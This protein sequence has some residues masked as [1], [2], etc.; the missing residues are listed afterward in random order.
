MYLLPLLTTYIR[1]LLTNA[2]QNYNAYSDY[3]GV[4]RFISAS[5]QT[6][7][8]NDLNLGSSLKIYKQVYF[9]WS[10]YDMI[11]WG[12]Y[13]LRITIRNKRTIWLK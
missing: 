13:I 5:V 11:H 9:A 6:N 3:H 10:L 8:S 7:Q 4:F 2:I 12:T 1:R